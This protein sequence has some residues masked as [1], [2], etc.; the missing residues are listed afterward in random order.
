MP[1]IIYGKGEDDFFNI[2]SNC[3]GAEFLE[4]YLEGNNIIPIA[5]IENVAIAITT[6]LK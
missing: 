3:L 5:Y 2:F 1:G 6:L 4:V